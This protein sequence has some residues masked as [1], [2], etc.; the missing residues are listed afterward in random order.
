MSS[1][2]GGVGRV[3]AILDQSFEEWLVR[4]PGEATRACFLSADFARLD[5]LRR[6]TGCEITQPGRRLHERLTRV[7]EPLV[8]LYLKTGMNRDSL[9]WWGSQI[10]SRSVTG[11]TA[12]LNVAY[13][14]F[15][16]DEMDRGVSGRH[17]IFICS[18]AAVCD[19]IATEARKRGIQGSVFKDRHYA[20]TRLK[21]IV[22][23]WVKSVQFLVSGISR[24]FLVRLHGCPV[25]ASGSKIT[26]LRSWC[27]PANVHEDG[28]F[29]DR[30]F[31][32]FPDRLTAA[33]RTVWISPCMLR[34][35]VS[36]A[37]MLRRMAKSRVRFLHAERLVSL[38]DIIGELWRGLREVHIRFED[39]VIDGC[40]L[41]PIFC[42]S[43]RQ[44]AV[45][46]ELIQFNL[47]YY[48]LARLA[49]AG[50]VVEQFYYPMEN[51]P[52]EKLPIRAMR[53]F[54]PSGLSCGFQHSAWFKN[55]YSMKLL[56]S[57]STTHPV[58]DRILYTGA[59]YRDV[60]AD[61]GFP[62]RKMVPCPSYRFSYTIRSLTDKKSPAHGDRRGILVLPGFDADHA[63]EL[64]WRT[65]R[66]TARIAPAVTVYVKPHPTSN[67][68]T[69]RSMI[70]REGKGRCEIVD[71]NAMDW[72]EKSVMVV[73]SG[74]SIAALEVILRGIPLLRSVPGSSYFLDP[75]WEDYPIPLSFDERELASNITRILSGDYDVVRLQDLARLVRDQYFEP[76]NGQ[77]PL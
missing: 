35:D 64:L 32:V 19:V 18:S 52:F 45:T 11:T 55:Q 29:S 24:W 23:P 62:T 65:L 28:T 51:N 61:C 71:G 13:A 70:E 69:I 42:E 4:H 26:L 48:C 49:K 2:G 38:G 34:L 20:K 72:V 6:R 76:D 67:L 75:L 63:N 21:L 68:D 37:G 54:H 31:G 43:V 77:L 17:L 41:A 40:D 73:D 30:N 14:L 7:A 1:S 59:R 27:T 47:I 57:E 36:F 39:T 16:C 25:P 3:T 60:L 74:G 66:A 22:R 44:G 46:P 9:V 56:S 58:P 50:C 10:A 5:H 33:G 15:A 53:D 8:E 12:P